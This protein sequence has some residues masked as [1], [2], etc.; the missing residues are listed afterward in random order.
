M[1]E[2]ERFMMLGFVS[3]KKRETALQLGVSKFMLLY[4]LGFHL[5]IL[6]LLLNIYCN[7]YSVTYISVG[8]GH[9]GL[10][11]SKTGPDRVHPYGPGFFHPWTG[12][13][14]KNRPVRFFCIRMQRVRPISVFLLSP[15]PMTYKSIKLINN[16]YHRKGHGTCP[17]SR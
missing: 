10:T 14:E 5:I 1:K 8:F 13:T 7:I 2:E 11:F 6:L 9:S 16:M 15:S 12:S 4:I 17:F 3:E